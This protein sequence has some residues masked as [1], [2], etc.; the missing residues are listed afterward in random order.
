MILLSECRLNFN[1]VAR[2]ASILTLLDDIDR[3]VK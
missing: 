3:W 1:L 2:D